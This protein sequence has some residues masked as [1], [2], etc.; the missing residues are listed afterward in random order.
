MPFLMHESQFQNRYKKQN[1]YKNSSAF[2]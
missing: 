2:Y 1:S